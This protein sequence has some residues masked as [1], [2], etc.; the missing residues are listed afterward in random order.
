MANMEVVQ[1]SCKN[2]GGNLEFSPNDQSLECP[3]CGT[4]NENPEVEMPEVYEELDFKTA[5][6]E[7][8]GETETMDLQLV[9]CTAC[10]A[11]VTLEANVTTAECDFCGTHLIASGKAEKAMKPQ[12]LLPFGIEREEALKTFRNWIQK[13]RFAP[14]DLKKRSKLSEPVKGIY[15][16][17]WTYDADTTSD[18]TG[19]RGTTY[20]R[21][22][23]SRNSDGSTSTRTVTEIRWRPASGTVKRF[24]DDVLVPASKTLIHK[25]IFRFKDWK[26]G[27]MVGYS[28][29]YLS[30]FKAE[31]YSIGLK[32]GF[33][34][35]KQT[36]SV[37]IRQDIRGDIGGDAQRIHRVDTK[38]KEITFKYILL[39][40]WVVMY[41]FKEKYFQVLINGKTGEIHGQRPVSVLKIILLAA[42]IAVVVLGIIF[43]VRYL[44]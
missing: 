6:E 21:T 36:M 42:V 33:E 9:S 44:K 3:F 24:F 37:R 39:P 40:I 34:D 23:S 27:E 41:K 1:F 26:L 17:F 31:S 11:E 13:R 8:G 25:L 22:V 28:T 15:Y 18:Y 20:T 7:I 4:V 10:Q 5:L 38:Y 12:Y 32:D 19:E 29:Q 2:C 14:N 16:P 35:A 43:L 30:G